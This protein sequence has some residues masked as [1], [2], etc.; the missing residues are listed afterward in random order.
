MKKRLFLLTF[1][2]I[3]VVLL[4]ENVFAST[5]EEEQTKGSLVIIGGAL[6]SENAEVY[7][8]FIELAGGKEN[9]RIGII[10]AASGSPHKY[11]NMFKEDLKKYGVPE[12]NIIIIPIAV[13]NDKRSK[14]IDESTW[15]DNGDSPE[16]A[17]LVKD[18]SGLWFVGGDQLKITQTLFREDGSNTL[19]LDAIWDIYKNGAVIGGTSAGAAIMSDVMIAGGDS[20]GAL[21]KGFTTEYDDSSLDQQNYGAAYVV[22]GLG[23]YKHGIIDQHFDRKSRLG[24][25]IVVGYN[26]KNN[27]PLSFG[28]DE[29]T[30]LVFYNETKLIEV[31]GTGGITIVDLS[32]AI[33]NPNSQIADIKD[34]M[35]SFIESGDSFNVTTKKFKINPDK[36]TTRGYEYMDVKD[37]MVTGLFSPN[38]LTKKFVTYGLV[39]NIGADEIKS[40]CYDQNGDGVALIFRKVPESQGYWGQNG[41]ADLYSFTNVALDIKP[42]K[43]HM[44]YTNEEGSP[45]EQSVSQLSDSIQTYEVKTGDVLWKIAAKFN[46]ETEKV[47]KL[48][49]LKN[50]NRIYTGQILII[51]K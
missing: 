39:D 47:I 29:N 40:F 31:V 27:S 43:V 9:A 46:I 13:K 35:I 15:A 3:I 41:S 21:T 12:E 34:I 16:V 28:V 2:L 42:I 49:N 33:K 25:L 14:D 17:K 6:T 44:E 8:K 18:C 4:T 45:L 50:P 36:L 51:P 24:R 48:N 23:F 10:P 37:P 7:N 19:V 1:A 22:K 32:K 11:S 26:E 30:G 38:A 20:L 5:S